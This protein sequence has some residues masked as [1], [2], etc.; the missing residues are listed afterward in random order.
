MEWDSYAN[1]EDRLSN[2]LVAFWGQQWF[3]LA[4]AGLCS[5]K[6]ITE[7]GLSH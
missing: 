2:L 7:A 3:V 4:G 5:D 6:V 1:E